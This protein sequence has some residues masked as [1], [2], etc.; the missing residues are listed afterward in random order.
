L[1]IHVA[2]ITNDPPITM[3]F[4][5]WQWALLLLAAAMFGLSKTGLPGVSLLAVGVLSNLMPAKVATGVVLPLL[6]F[7]DLFASFVYRKHLDWRHVGRLLPSAV[8]GVALGWLALGRIDDRQTAQLV[9]VIIAVMLAVHLW[10]R[11][12][13]SD[14]VVRAPVWF[15]PLMGLFA[16]FTTMIANAAGP[17]M[18]LYLLAM[19]L[20]KLKFLGVTAAFFLLINWIKVPFALQLGLINQ[21]SLWLNLWLLP[22]VAVGALSGRA[23]VARIDQRRFENIALVLSGLA[24]V[25]LL[26][27]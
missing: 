11:R 22:A 12:V 21:D 15:G 4:T 14:E 6:I 2:V 27:A 18:I 16:G 25:K 23:I 17:V 8:T 3:D 9:G 1:V 10:R 20:E 5:F 26:L 24:V 7:A 13:G 19:R